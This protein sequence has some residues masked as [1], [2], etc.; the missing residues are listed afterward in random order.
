MRKTGSFLPQPGRVELY[1]FYSQ[2]LFSSIVCS[3][4]H[5]EEQFVKELSVRNCKCTHS[6]SDYARSWVTVG[7]KAEGH[8]GGRVQLFRDTSDGLLKNCTFHN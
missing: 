3:K 8:S 1:F 2:S 7:T 5:K 6:F 4:K